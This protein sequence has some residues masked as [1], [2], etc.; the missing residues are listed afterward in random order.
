MPK[1][2]KTTP[3]TE[4]D[5]KPE[6]YLTIPNATALVSCA[7]IS[8]LEFHLWGSRDDEGVARAVGPRP[9]RRGRGHARPDQRDREERPRAR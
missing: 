1:E 2:I 3:I 9:R 4:S 5:G 8:A 7:Q 6:D